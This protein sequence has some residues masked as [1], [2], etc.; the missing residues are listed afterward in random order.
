MIPRFLHLNPITRKRLRKF[1][2]QRLGYYSFIVLS[3]M[4]VFSFFANYVANSRALIVHYNG[5]YYFPTFKFIPSTTFDQEDIYGGSDTDYRKLSESFKGT[6]NWL[7]MPPIKFNPLENDFDFYSVPPPNPP[8]SRHLLGTDDKGRDVFA[9]LLYGLRISILFSFALV[10]VS[11]VLGV[12]VGCAQ[13]YFSGWFDITSQRVIEVWSTLPLLYVVVLLNTLIK[14]SFFTLLFVLILFEW[15][16][17][18]YYM[19]TELY[20]E[21]TKEYVF[22]A[23]SM[24]ASH[25]RIIFRH[26]LPNALVP[27][28]TFT[29]FAIVGGIFILTALDY[30]GYGLPPPTPSWGQLV[31]QALESSNRDKLWLSLSPFLAI[32]TTL[33]L[34]TLIGESIREAFD[35]KPF[36]RYR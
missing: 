11:T 14:P 6:D 33:V 7:V 36:A 24:G 2:Q 30:L 5:T 32:T 13:G 23:R 29:P 1:R 9:R 31:D 19:R 4:I 20:R 12:I 17:I 8:D 21:K 25:F 18:T 28:V 3:C 16:V 27:I 15:Y 26:L 34:V 22:A 35:P 10:A